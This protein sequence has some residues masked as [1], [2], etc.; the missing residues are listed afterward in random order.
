MTVYP[1]PPRYSRYL[2]DLRDKH[3]PS[4]YQKLPQALSEDALQADLSRTQVPSTVHITLR[5][6]FQYCNN[7]PLNENYDLKSEK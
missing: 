6:E 3:S 2:H 1:S 5:L 7:S 4:N